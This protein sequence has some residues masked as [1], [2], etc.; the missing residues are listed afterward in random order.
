MTTSNCSVDQLLRIDDQ[1]RFITG[2]DGSRVRRRLPREHGPGFLGTNPE[3]SEGADHP[4]LLI[5]QDQN[6]FSSHAAPHLGFHL[7]QEPF[8]KRVV[9]RDLRRDVSEGFSVHTHSLASHIAW[10]KE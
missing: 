2:N 10:G 8:W 6:L 7:V 4:D 1:R 3:T 9:I 5:A